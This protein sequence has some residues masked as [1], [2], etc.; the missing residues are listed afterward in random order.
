VGPVDDDGGQD[1]SLGGL[2]AAAVEGGGGVE[3]SGW[4]KFPT[5]DVKEYVL[6]ASNFECGFNLPVGDFFRGL[7]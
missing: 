6:F 5:E 1:P 3:G 7:L 4:G 2:R